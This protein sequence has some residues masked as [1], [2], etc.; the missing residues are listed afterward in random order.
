[1]STLLHV[2]KCNLGELY[3]VP[4]GCALLSGFAIGARVARATYAPDA[5]C[6]QGWSE[7]DE[8]K[9]GVDSGDKMKHTGRN[10][11]FI[12]NEDD[13]DGR[14]RVTTDE[15]RVLRGA[16]REMKLCRYGS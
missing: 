8:E 13:A 4:P 11:Q 15:E 3:G 1:M 6:Q 16:G 2:R 5:K 9:Q 14:D 7:A 10:V 12:R